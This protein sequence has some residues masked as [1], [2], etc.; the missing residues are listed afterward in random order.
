M[1]RGLPGGEHPRDVVQRIAVYSP[2]G[3]IAKAI[4]VLQAR[5]IRG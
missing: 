4:D 5:E 3:Q 2:A 1:M